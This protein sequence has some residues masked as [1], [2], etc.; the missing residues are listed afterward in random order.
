MGDMRLKQLTL[1]L[2]ILYPS[3][4]LWTFCPVAPFTDKI[5]TFY[6]S[7]GVYS[8]HWAE[9]SFLAR[10]LFFSLWRTSSVCAQESAMDHAKSIHCVFVFYTCLTIKSNFYSVAKILNILWKIHQNDWNIFPQ[11]SVGRSLLYH[12]ERESECVVML[13]LGLFSRLEGNITGKRN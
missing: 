10:F 4:G 2:K 12:W 11:R 6:I 3:S 13:Q 1:R 5:N 9:I 7:G 8:Y